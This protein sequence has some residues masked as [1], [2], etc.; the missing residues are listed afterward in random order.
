[1]DNR[2]S[3]ITDEEMTFADVKR[4]IEL[5]TFEKLEAIMISE[6]NDAG[7]IKNALEVEI[8]RNK[9]YREKCNENNLPTNIKFIDYMIDNY[10]KIA[11]KHNVRIT[12]ND[13]TK[14]IGFS[15]I[16]WKYKTPTLAYLFYKLEEDGLINIENTGAT[17]SKMFVD[18]RHN[19]IDNITLNKYLSQFRLPKPPNTSNKEYIDNIISIIKTIESEL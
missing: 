17:L 1:M 19:D 12:K 7:G 10:I 9:G 16:K 5:F 13:S 3:K 18:N 11:E 2:N 15:K 6:A 14:E 8:M 4:L